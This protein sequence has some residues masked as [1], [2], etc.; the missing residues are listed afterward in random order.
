MIHMIFT[1]SSSAILRHFKIAFS[2]V[3]RFSFGMIPCSR[4]RVHTVCFDLVNVLKSYDGDGDGD[5]NAGI[6]EDSEEMA[7][8]IAVEMEME[9]GTLTLFFQV[10]RDQMFSGTYVLDYIERSIAALPRL[11]PLDKTKIS[12]KSWAMETYTSTFNAYVDVLR[13]A[14][15]WL[16]GSEPVL[17]T[18]SSVYE[19]VHFMVMA[20]EN[21]SSGTWTPTPSLVQD[22]LDV[23][24]DLEHNHRHS[25]EGLARI[26]RQKRFML[27]V[28]MP[29]IQ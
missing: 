23:L 10:R 4:H 3:A 19:M 12:M 1:C 25:R 22:V 24:Q 17:A 7:K 8:G 26:Q 13:L 2:F 21:G 15:N 6:E 9:M 14:V 28:I 16:K 11:K 27:K 29:R 18:P 20:M 5:G